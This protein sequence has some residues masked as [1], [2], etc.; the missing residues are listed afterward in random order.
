MLAPQ[1]AILE[2]GGGSA[3]TKL[4]A[5]APS[6]SVGTTL[7]LGPEFAGGTLSVGEDVR[8]HPAMKAAAITTTGSGRTSAV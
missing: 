8:T 6:V 5:T 7:A 1:P 4:I 3:E 2:P